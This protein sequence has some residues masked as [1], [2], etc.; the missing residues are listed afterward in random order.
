MVKIP[1]R[2]T[3]NGITLMVKVRTRSSRRG[4]EG[5]EGNA[6]KVRVMSPP[7]DD[8]ANREL[9]ELLSE[10]LNIKKSAFRIIKGQSSPC[11][12]IAITGKESI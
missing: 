2:R 6:L 12:T 3:K 11:K 1:H 9:I 4:I 7:V 5:I 8:A 10:A